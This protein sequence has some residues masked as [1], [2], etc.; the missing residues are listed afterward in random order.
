MAGIGKCMGVMAGAGLL[1]GAAS[2]YLIQS[3]FNKAVMEGAKIQAKDGYVPIGGRTK[4]GKLWDGKM[5]LEDYQK[6]L[7]KKAAVTSL[8]NGLITATGTAIIAGF[9]LLLRGKVK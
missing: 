8:I 5:K 7:Q 9:T 3:H 6:M 4:D 2:S 1:G